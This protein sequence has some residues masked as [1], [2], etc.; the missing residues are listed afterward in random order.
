[1]EKAF[2]S[3]ILTSV[4]VGALANVTGRFVSDMINSV[5]SK[6]LKFSS[7]KEYAVSAVTGAISGV[8]YAVGKPVLTNYIANS[9]SSASKQ[10]YKKVDSVKKGLEVCVNIAVEAGFSTLS[11]RITTKV[12]GITKGRNSFESVYK[13]NL[14]KLKNNTAKKMSANVIRKGFEAQVTNN[15]FSI[16]LNGLMSYTEDQFKPYMGFEFKILNWD[17]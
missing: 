16:G 11:D 3:A 8:G 14:T 1:M 7:P 12:S 15:G 9:V 13:A 17:D 2:F 6:K 5:I 4:V 10:D